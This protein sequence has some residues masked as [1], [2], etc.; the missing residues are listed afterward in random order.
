MWATRERFASKL[1]IGLMKAR[2]RIAKRRCDRA[3]GIWSNLSKIAARRTNY[4]VAVSF[5]ARPFAPFGCFP[6]IE[7]VMF[8]QYAVTVVTI[9]AAFVFGMVLALLGSLKLALAKRMNLGEGRIGFLLSALN[10]ALMPMMILT[11]ML[12]DNGIG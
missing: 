2:W 4:F 9:S 11:G 8:G 1:K 12:I 7:V 5:K 3:S 10:F 6:G